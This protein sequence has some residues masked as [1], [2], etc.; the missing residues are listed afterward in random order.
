MDSFAISSQVAQLLPRMQVVVVV[1][2]NVQLS[3]TTQERV[4]A[5]GESTAESTHAKLSSFPNAQSHPLIARYR[6]T[7]KKA[8][9][10]SAKKF[11]QSNESLY[12]RLI[13]DGRAPRPINP[14]VDFY[15]AVS[16]K[17]GVT[18]GAFDLTD[19]AALPSSGSAPASLELRLSGSSDTFLALDVAPDSDPVLI[20]PGEISYARGNIILTRHL[21]WRQSSQ[22]LVQEGTRDVV[23]VSEI[24]NEQ[25]SPE[26]S[27]LAKAVKTDLVNGLRDFFDVAEPLKS[28]LGQGL[29]SLSTPL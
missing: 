10:L 12:K 13:K 18:A 26:A 11:P 22:G 7:L 9:S 27:E 17:H 3:A 28:I 20:P 8:V 23:I 15:N 1:A 25:D 16:I 21:A 4:R 14:L 19:L 2:R 24:F 6:D 5:F 29:D